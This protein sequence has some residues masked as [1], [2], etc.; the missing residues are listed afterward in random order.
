MTITPFQLAKEYTNRDVGM[1]RKTLFLYVVS[2]VIMGISGALSL[3]GFVKLLVLWSI[4]LVALLASLWFETI[5]IRQCVRFK[6]RIVRQLLLYAFVVLM[7]FRVLQNNDRY[8][9][10]FFFFYIISF[11]I[12]WSI[13]AAIIVYIAKKRVARKDWE[14]LSQKDKSDVLSSLET[15]FKEEEDVLQKPICAV[16][17]LVIQIGLIL[18]SLFLFFKQGQGVCALDL[19]TV[20]NFTP[21]M[22]WMAFLKLWVLKQS[23]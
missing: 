13:F 20:S 21:Q 4:A 10:A 17:G 3:I 12:L 19:I 14:A 7:A 5:Q 15:L 6:M 18:L 22:M 1:N 2:Y 8:Q 16:I 9:T 11:Y 23:E